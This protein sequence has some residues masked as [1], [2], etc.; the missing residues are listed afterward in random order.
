MKT[1][2]AIRVKSYGK[3]GCYVPLGNDGMQKLRNK[4]RRG[5]LRETEILRKMGGTVYV[6]PDFT[7]EMCNMSERQLASYVM[8][9]GTILS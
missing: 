9:H 7:Q 6:L 8:Q 5:W 4:T 1:M 3:Y 2:W